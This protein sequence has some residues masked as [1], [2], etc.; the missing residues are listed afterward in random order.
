VLF[1]LEEPG[2]K[3]RGEEAETAI[4]PANTSELSITEFPVDVAKEAVTG[5]GAPG[6]WEFEEEAEEREEGFTQDEV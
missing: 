2:R 3:Q 6:G 4:A 5:P 1:I